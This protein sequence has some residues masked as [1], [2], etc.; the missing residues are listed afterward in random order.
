MGA[1]RALI[2]DDSK[3]ARLF[4]SRILVQHA[5]EVETVESA[6][7]AID[8]LTDH[9]PDV[10]FMDHQMPG[11][12]GLQAVRIIKNNPITATIPIMMYTSQ[13]GELYLGQARALGAVGVMP[14]QIKQAD[15]SKVLYELHLLPERRS[16]DGS[17][18]RPVT[19]DSLAEAAVEADRTGSMPALPSIT[20][21]ALREQFDELRRALITS[22]ETQSDRIVADFHA[23]LR[24]TPLFATTS[25]EPPPAERPWAWVIASI[26]LI[27]ALASAGLWWREANL[28]QSMIA[29]LAAIRAPQAR[30]PALPAQAKPSP[31]LAATAQGKLT[32][33]EG[34]F[35]PTVIQVPYGEDPLAGPRLETIRQL[36]HRLISQK[37]SGVVDIRTFPGRFCLVGNLSDGYSLAP[38]ELSYSRCDAVGN[39]AAADLA[40]REP[41]G[42]ANLVGELRSGTRGAANARVFAGDTVT[43]LVSYPAISPSLTAGEWNRAA[44]SN[45]RVEIRLR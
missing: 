10:I 28:R 13:E 24:D 21:A 20:E 25:G 19:L 22:I 45:N 26:A 40:Q 35:K 32:A 41:L 3:S 15:V 4:L 27:V 18:L 42:F 14:K 38:D 16:L 31:G 6:E 43:T 44:A 17:G 39:P 36:F 8:Y 34:G 5:I 2:V 37:F 9:R 11:M 30:L 1:K 12:D 29:Q 23:G 33:G 7:S